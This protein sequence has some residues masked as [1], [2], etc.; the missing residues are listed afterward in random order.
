MVKIVDLLFE[1][2]SNKFKASVASVL[3][4]LTIQFF[5]PNY[6]QVA[7]A[8]VLPGTSSTEALVFT[9][10]LPMAEEVPLVLDRTY[11]IAV[12]A[13][14]SLPE[15]TD[16]TPCI[17]ANGFDLC[18]HNI[19]NVIATNMLPFGTKVKFPEYDADRVFTVQDR[20]N[21]RYYQ[22][23]DI[24]MREKSDARAFGIKYLTMEVYK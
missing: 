6:A 1:E 13:Y 11:K 9:N 19:E 21:A 15:Q 23:A 18:K 2:K 7:A 17:T 4:V 3:A 20:M 22:R 24:W 10:S 16:D 12:T 14:N 5:F 8:Q